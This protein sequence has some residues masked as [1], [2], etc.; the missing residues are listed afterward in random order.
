MIKAKEWDGKDLE[1]NWLVTLK[2]DG[3]RALSDGKR[4]LSRN[5]KLLY[6]CQHLAHKFTDAE[7]YCGSFKQT[8]QVVRTVKVPTELQEEFVVQE[9]EVYSLN[10]LDSRL[11]QGH[12]NNPTAVDIIK[13]MKLAV[14]RGY[15]GL[16]LRNGDT[17]LKVKPE[18]TYDVTI[19]ALVEGKGK[20]KGRLGKFMTD[21]G[22]VGTG[23]TDLQRQEYWTEKMVG[24]T[25]E[26]ACMQLTTD[27]KFRHP[28]FVRTRFDK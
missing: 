8:I 6:N 14:R 28:R 12:I 9:N 2:I 3:V 15:E 23:F 10:P 16:V 26:V 5:G 22:G 1:G 24:T 11:I 13:L 17:W 27:G 21:M 25:I 19:T 18:C 20:H 7:I 4:V